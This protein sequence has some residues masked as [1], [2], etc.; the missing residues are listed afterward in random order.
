MKMKINQIIFSILLLTGPSI[1]AMEEPEE[2]NAN[3]KIFEVYS[4]SKL[5][6]IAFAKK[7]IEVYDARGYVAM[8]EL[9][10][11]KAAEIGMPEEMLFDD[12]YWA[13]IHISYR[14]DIFINKLLE[15]YLQNPEDP[16]ILKFFKKF[17]KYAQ[18]EIIYYLTGQI[19]A[20]ADQEVQ[21]NLLKVLFAGHPNIDFC[22]RILSYLSD[23]FKNLAQ[24]NESRKRAIYT[25]SN[26][27]SHEK[28]QQIKAT[29]MKVDF[30][31]EYIYNLICIIRNNL[32][33]HIS[34]IQSLYKEPSEAFVKKAQELIGLFG[35]YKRST[36]SEE[37]ETVEV[38]LKNLLKDTS[39]IDLQTIIDYLFNK[40]RME[41][42]RLIKCFG[43][44]GQIKKFINY[45]Y[46]DQATAE[47]ELRRILITFL[48]NRPGL[49][50]FIYQRNL[51]VLNGTSERCFN[52]KQ[53]VFSNMF[54]KLTNLL[55]NKKN[56]DQVVALLQ[57]DYSEFGL[58][59]ID[60]ELTDLIEFIH[61]M[62]NLELNSDLFNNLKAALD[63]F[64]KI[65]GV[66]VKQF[67]TEF[68]DIASYLKEINKKIAQAMPKAEKETEN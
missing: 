24:A 48:R 52:I 22:E 62:E 45:V 58:E 25:N 2:K 21:F 18:F 27:F 23:K 56:Q 68:R 19:T 43:T 59:F 37:K 38:Q 49:S 20:K 60:M 40:Y 9:I 3:E 8:N 41:T 11:R 51:A 7:A 1:F 33:E 14:E 34:N 50:R 64:I 26:E 42:S 54:K 65:S 28:K 47:K 16:S 30:A 63:Q 66:D 57:D 13:V 6:A 5:A 61:A 29:I 15:L 12:V 39:I 46:P 44:I 55:K 10:E 36:S 31:L 32:F 35:S 4:L 67:W 17:D 53:I